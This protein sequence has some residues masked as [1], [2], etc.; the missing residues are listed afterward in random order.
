[1]PLR[2]VRNATSIPIRTYPITTNGIAIYL[3]RFFFF[4]AASEFEGTL[5]SLAAVEYSFVKEL[6]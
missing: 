3:A 2:A 6:S 4:F 1:M 5:S